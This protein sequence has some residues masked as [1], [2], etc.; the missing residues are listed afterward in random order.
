M[1]NEKTAL[2]LILK[3]ME[4]ALQETGFAPV[5][6][7]APGNA[8]LF[9]RGGETLRVKVED[10]RAALQH[11]P[12]EPELA[13]DGDFRQL[14]VT[15]LELGAAAEG[16]C[17]YVAGDFAEAVQEKFRVRKKGAPMAPGAKL[18]KSISKTAI[19]NGEAYYDALSFGNSFTSM[20]PELRAGYKAN[21][22][23]YGEFLAEEFFLRGG[24]NEVVLRIVQSDNKA[25]LN[26]LFGLFNEVYENGVNDVQSLICV[27]ILGALDEVLLARCADYMSTDLAPVAIRVNRYL[28][29]KAGT[30]AKEKLA[31]PPLYKPK[32]R[33]K[34]GLLSQMMGGGGQGLGQ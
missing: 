10:D 2:D 24:G 27:T 25:Q 28:G 14:A 29:S 16:D 31:N 11:C 34:Q 8:A 33:K 13:M 30:R 26:R 19:K 4:P 18:P 5:R 9:T 20:F 23:K 17:R 21:Y 15:L 12:R 22:E 3:G 6:P 32:R 1:M 7:A